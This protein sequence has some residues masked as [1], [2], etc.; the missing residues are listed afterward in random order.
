M[1][2]AIGSALE[3]L[4][5]RCGNNDGSGERNL[6]SSLVLSCLESEDIKSEASRI[7][8]FFENSA[9]TVDESTP[10]AYADSLRKYLFLQMLG[11]SFDSWPQTVQETYR[12][13]VEIPTWDSFQIVKA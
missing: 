8:A 9:A 2:S 11:V 12:R 4:Y 1:T 5:R 10:N 6:S 7:F 3:R 13:C